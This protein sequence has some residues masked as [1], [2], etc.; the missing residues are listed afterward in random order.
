MSRQSEELPPSCMYPM[1]DTMLPSKAFWSCGPSA[2]NARLWCTRSASRRVSKSPAWPPHGLHTKLKPCCPQRLQR[3]RCIRRY[4]CLHCV[5]TISTTTDSTEFTTPPALN[6]G[7]AK[8]TLSCATAALATS[9][10]APVSRSNPQSQ[11]SLTPQQA[12]TKQHQSP[13]PFQKVLLS[14]FLPSSSG[15]VDGSSLLCVNIRYTSERDV[16]QTEPY[17]HLLYC[18]YLSRHHHKTQ[19]HSLDR[20]RNDTCHQT[21]NHHGSRHNKAHGL[22]VDARYAL[23]NST[24]KKS[25]HFLTSLNLGNFAELWDHACDTK[26]SNA[27]ST[28][29][30]QSSKS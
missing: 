3:I 6:I 10:A 21:C 26:T 13:H 30:Q 9:R 29:R 22:T 5:S 17:F 15:P 23:P 4:H 28:S 7:S 8:E 11:H 12:Q 19:E 27:S 1:L 16:H 14:S 25:I 18:F 20:L 2:R 24:Y